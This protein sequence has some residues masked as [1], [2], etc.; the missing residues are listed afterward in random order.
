MEFPRLTVIIYPIK[1]RPL[2]PGDF[3]VMRHFP[4]QAA[5]M[6]YPLAYGPK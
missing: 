4:A 2:Q 1:M 3:I 6:L 5:A